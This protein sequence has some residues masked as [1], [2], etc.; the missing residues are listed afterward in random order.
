MALTDLVCVVWVASC[1]AIFMRPNVALRYFGL[2]LLFALYF[3]NSLRVDGV[4]SL[5]YSDNARCQDLVRASACA[6]L[7]HD[8]L[9][10]AWCASQLSTCSHPRP[11]LW[12]SVCL[13]SRCLGSTQL[14]FGTFLCLLVQALTPG[15]GARPPAVR[16]G[17]MNEPNDFGRTSTFRHVLHVE[18]TMKGTLTP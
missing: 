12:V 10:A 16:T 13:E 18:R 15:G 4:L 6:H 17:S 11:L 7:Y 8:A 9:G 14:K 5:N 2:G 3:L 1:H